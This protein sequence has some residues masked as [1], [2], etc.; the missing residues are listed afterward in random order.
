[1][2]QPQPYVSSILVTFVN[3]F[4]RQRLFRTV[5]PALPCSGDAFYLGQLAYE[6]ANCE[7]SLEPAGLV[8]L[9]VLL[10]PQLDADEQ[11]PLTYPE[12]AG[13]WAQWVEGPLKE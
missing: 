2:N 6:V 11:Q 1:M 9:L 5:L 4:T 13:L 10:R 3:L 12:E 8:E 7:W